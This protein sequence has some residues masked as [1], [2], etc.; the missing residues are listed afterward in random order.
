MN[1]LDRIFG[2]RPL[3]QRSSNNLQAGAGIVADSN[4]P[5]CQECG[6]TGWV[7]RPPQYEWERY[8]DERE[9]IECRSCGGS[10]VEA[11]QP[12]SRC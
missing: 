4:R 5:K 11:D 7:M 8:G 1:L 12:S 6:G 3:A 2:K 10:G 9:N